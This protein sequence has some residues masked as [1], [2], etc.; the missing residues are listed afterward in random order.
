MKASATVIV[1][2]CG[3]RDIVVDQ[4]SSAPFSVRQCDGR[5]LLASSAAAPVGGD[6]LDLTV[7]VRSGARAAIGSVAASMVWPGIDGATSS[8]TTE[9]VVGHGAHLDLRLEPTIS[10]AGSRHRTATTVR[11]DGDA[12]CRLVEESVLGRRDEL[13]GHLEVSM[14]VERGGRP[15]V[16]HDERFGPDVAGAWSSVSVGAARHVVSAVLVGIDCGP[17]QVRVESAR[18]AAWLPIAPDAAMVMAVAHDRPGA[19]SLLAT[20][21]P[22][23]A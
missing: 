19:M 15:L 12:T 5:I 6:E 16:H 14:R 8:M 2:R 9:C 10:V 17:P 22:D 18:A 3:G 23:F 13:S 21:S 7:D 4:R 1:A 11:L 20:L